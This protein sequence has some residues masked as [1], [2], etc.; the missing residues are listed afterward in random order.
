MSFVKGRNRTR[1]EVSVSTRERNDS[2]SRLR[3]ATYRDYLK[4]DL[5]RSIRDKLLPATCE[6]CSEPATVVHHTSYA[7]DVMKGENKIHLHPVCNSCHGRAKGR[8][9]TIAKK[10]ACSSCGVRGVKFRKKKKDQLCGDCKT[11]RADNKRIQ[12]KKRQ[13]NMV[14]ESAV[15][16]TGLDAMFDAAM[17]FS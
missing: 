10:P 6:C 9:S 13:E 2:L 4:S 3:F 14:A 12:Q 15:D 8:T 1:S 17:R 11:L 5:W 7:L 16:D